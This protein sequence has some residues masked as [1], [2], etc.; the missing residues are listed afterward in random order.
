LYVV[1]A[2]CAAA[3]LYRCAHEHALRMAR[4]AAQAGLARALAVARSLPAASLHMLGEH[5]EALLLANK[6]PGARPPLRLAAPVA[7]E[8]EH[9][10]LVARIR[11]L[12]GEGRAAAALAREGVAL[13]AR[14]GA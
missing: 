4:V 12:Q 9:A 6:A 7:G 13:A 2:R 14:D 1:A 11:W 10:M 3:G 8:V 5:G